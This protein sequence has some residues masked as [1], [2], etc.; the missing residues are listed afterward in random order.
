[1]AALAVAGCS[2]EHDSDTRRA[3]EQVA[4]I[5][6][7]AE[8]TPFGVM[9]TGAAIPV[10]SS[11]SVKTGSTA[12]SAA[13]SPAAGG[14]SASPAASTAPQII[15][16]HTSPAIIHDGDTLLWTVQTTPDVVDVVA[17]VTVYAFRLQKHGTGQYILS[18]TIPHGVPGFFHGNYTLDLVARS[19][20]GAEATTK[21]PVAFQ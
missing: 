12:A 16:V 14:S 11:S 4:A 3:P 5:A 15:S 8:A 17:H 2:G 1:V 6:S 20:T 7:D 18:F 13:A 21:V 10:A 19:A 9:P